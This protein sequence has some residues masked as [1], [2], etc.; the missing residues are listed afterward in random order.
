MIEEEQQKLLEERVREAL[1]EPDELTTTAEF[2]RRMDEL[3]QA[4]GYLNAFH[5]EHAE[6]L[7]ANL[8][9]QPKVTLEQALEQYQRIKRGSKPRKP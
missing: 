8:A 3:A 5:R 9:K 1:A 4:D 7:K 2:K 6:R